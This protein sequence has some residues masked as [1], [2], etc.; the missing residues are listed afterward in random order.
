MI[1]PGVLV[2]IFGRAG[3]RGALHAR[4]RTGGGLAR[5]LLVTA[6]QRVPP[7]PEGAL[8]FRGVVYFAP[9]EIHWH[10]ATPETYM[11]HMAINIAN[12]T[13]GGTEWMDPITDEEYAGG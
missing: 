1:V 9:G 13:D 4:G 3:V 8:E 10:G 5:H 11:V 7:P 2:E 6:E 12:T